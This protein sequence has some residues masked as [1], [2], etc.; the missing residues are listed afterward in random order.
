MPLNSSYRA[1]QS[2]PLLSYVQEP[3]AFWVLFGP[4][5]GSVAICRVRDQY[6][7][8]LSTDG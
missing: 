4:T 8:L 6:T 3:F 1:S 7:E 5:Q 2:L